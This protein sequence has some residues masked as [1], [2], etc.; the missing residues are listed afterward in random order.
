MTDLEADTS[1]AGVAQ[2]IEHWPADQRV[3]SSIPSPEHMPGLQARS[4]VGGMWEAI[5][6][7][8]FSSSLSPS[9]PLYKNKLNKILK[10][11]KKKQTQQVCTVPLKGESLGGNLL[12]AVVLTGSK[13]FRNT[14]WELSSVPAAQSLEQMQS[15]MSL[16]WQWICA[17]K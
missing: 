17:Q 14:S 9:F 10:K 5:T 3:T 8:C 7:W 6:H 4:P 15:G 11:K 12:K 16:C 2:W 1:L 13:S